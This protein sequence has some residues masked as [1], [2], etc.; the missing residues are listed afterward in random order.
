E[1]DLRRL[2]GQI[3]AAQEQERRFLSRELHD[4]AGQMLTGLRM[5]LASISYVAGEAEFSER[6]GHAKGIAEQC[7][8]VIRNITMMLRPS[9]LDDLGLNSALGWLTREAM[10]SSSVEI[11]TDIDPDLDALPDTHCTCIYRV[12]Q[13]ALTN[14]VRHS[15]AGRIDI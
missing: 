6:V 11:R 9:M 3:R 10:R 7:L 4:Q 5:E 2:S 12:V 13:E 8:R 14:A 1:E 15:G